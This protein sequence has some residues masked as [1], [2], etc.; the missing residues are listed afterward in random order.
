MYVQCKC[1]CGNNNNNKEK[2]KIK[3]KKWKEICF[4][5]TSQRRFEVLP[6]KM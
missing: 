3:E 6:I 1:M 2:Q 4:F 5:G